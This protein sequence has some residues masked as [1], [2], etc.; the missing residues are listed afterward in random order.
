MPDGAVWTVFTA[1][2]HEICFEIFAAPFMAP[3]PE[4]LSQVG[5]RVRMSGIKNV[6]FF[7]AL[8]PPEFGVETHV[9][10]WLSILRVFD[11]PIGMIAVEMAAIP[12]HEWG[13]PQA[14][15]KAGSANI[16]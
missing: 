14:R 1:K 10:K 13:D 3:G 11:N 16:F 7:A 15:G 6:V 4:D 5:K 2:V 8:V 9:H 12:R